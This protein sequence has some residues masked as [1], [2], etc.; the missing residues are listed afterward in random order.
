VN[1][2]PLQAQTVIQGNR[3]LTSFTIQATFSQADSSVVQ[4]TPI[5]ESV[6]EE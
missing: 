2:L 5:L 3:P 6:V 1:V 4:T